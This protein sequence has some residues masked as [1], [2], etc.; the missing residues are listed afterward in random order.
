MKSSY[1]VLGDGQVWLVPRERN[2]VDEVGLAVGS[3]WLL[4]RP[5]GPTTISPS[6]AKR[7]FLSVSYLS[8]SSIL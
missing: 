7:D 6:T 1:Q 5:P 3:G 4:S 8:V 2:I